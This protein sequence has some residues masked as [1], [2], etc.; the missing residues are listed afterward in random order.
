MGVELVDL[1]E[2]K[3]IPLHP[4][5]SNG[6]AVASISDIVPQCIACQVIGHMGFNCSIAFP[7]SFPH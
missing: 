6:V 2:G 5:G 4:T 1:R 7:W 3:D